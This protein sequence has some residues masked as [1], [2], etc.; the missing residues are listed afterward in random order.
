MLCLY[1]YLIYLID[2]LGCPGRDE[3]GDPAGELAH[4]GC[5]IDA[6]ALTEV[7]LHPTWPFWA[8][9]RLEVAP[10]RPAKRPAEAAIIVAKFS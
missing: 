4:K 9:N 8:S 3:T 2:D 7:D 1:V 10:A 5:A 6:E